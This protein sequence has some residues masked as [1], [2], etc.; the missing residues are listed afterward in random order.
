MRYRLKH[1]AEYAA[2]RAASAILGRLPY[3][4]A[5][6]LGWLLALLLWLAMP[7]RRR[8]A[9]RRIGAVLGQDTKAPGN[10][11]QV[12]WRAWRNLVF[13]SLDTMR[14]PHLTEAWIRRAVDYEGADLLCARLRESGRIILAVPHMG[15]WEMAGMAMHFFGLRMSYIVRRQ[16]NPLVDA[17]LNRLRTLKGFACIERDDRALVRV[18]LRHIQ[19]GRVL[20]ILPDVRA[21]DG[22]F[23]VRF[24]GGRAAV[25]K[26]MA[27]FAKM[28]GAPIL[29]ACTCREGWT[30]H[31]WQVFAPIYP[32]ATLDR[33]ADVQRMT[34][35]V[36]DLFDQAVREHPDQ[37][38]WFNK[39]WILEPFAPPAA[40]SAQKL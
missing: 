22:S 7:G 9:Q 3:R 36:F 31:R 4:L 23:Q 32:D 18:A 26:G 20:T 11:R 33:D 19:E 35:Q 2:M 14:L 40:D 39:R 30:R 38:F 12:A 10:A 21:R 37:Y 24:L 25:M 6:G 17:Y 27:V 29:P 28:T 8:E 1:L 15:S 13:S 5:L 16:K 34:Q